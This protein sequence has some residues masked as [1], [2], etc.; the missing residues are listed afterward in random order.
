MSTAVIP[1]LDNRQIKMK[2]FI[3]L[4]FMILTCCYNTCVAEI[5]QTNEIKV[6]EEILASID[7]DALV[8]LDVDEVLIMPKDQILQSPHREY[9]NKL[10]T[11]LFASEQ[12]S[13]NLWSIIFAQ[14]SSIPVDTK[15]INMINNL[16]S[17]GIKVMALT[18]AMTGKFGYITSMKD[19]RYN[20]L[21]SHGY[22]FEKS[23]KGIQDKTFNGLEKSSNCLASEISSPP[24]FFKGIIFT[25]IDKGEALEAFL[26]HYKLKFKKIIFID[27]K[28][29]NLE[30]VEKI[31][32][33]L[34][35]PFVGIEYTTAVIQTEP[36]NKKRAELQFQVLGKQRKWIP[37]S[38]ADALLA[39]KNN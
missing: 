17:K 16:Q 38:E 4:I 18:H 39:E 19:W 1:T 37:D 14:R 12:E 33:K 15:M 5:M 34:N 27:D 10:D 26:S 8:I 11:F 32:A 23:W 30:S 13:E 3:G 24:M 31:T 25:E 6:I 20:E 28:K 35:I 2:K 9:I 22:D 36:L 21:I 7:P 29:K